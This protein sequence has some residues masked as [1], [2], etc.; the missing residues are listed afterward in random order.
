MNPPEIILLVADDPTN[1]DSVYGNGDTITITFD[2]N[3]DMA[4]FT[5]TEP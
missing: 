4:G 2:V 1:A 3:T 5:N